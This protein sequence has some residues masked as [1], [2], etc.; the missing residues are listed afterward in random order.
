MFVIALVPFSMGENRV[1]LGKCY[2]NVAFA[3][4]SRGTNNLLSPSSRE[5]SWYRIEAELK[6]HTCH[7]QTLAVQRR[8]G[9]GDR[10]MEGWMAGKEHN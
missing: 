8:E 1:M 10:G 9:R 7:S 5:D 2:S 3:W 4:G 6:I